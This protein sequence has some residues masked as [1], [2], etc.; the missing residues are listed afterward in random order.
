MASYV[1][2]KVVIYL[3]S[4]LLSILVSIFEWFM[5]LPFILTLRYPVVSLVSFRYAPWWS[6]TYVVISGLYISYY[7]I[8]WDGLTLA[9]NYL[10]KLWA[11]P[12][13]I[14]DYFAI[15]V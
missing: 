11:I 5:V 6:T 7:C 1:L 8:N 15:L 13:A 3:L 10:G 12:T 14:F 2:P 9:E 4:V